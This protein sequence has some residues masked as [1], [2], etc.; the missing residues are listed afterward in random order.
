MAREPESVRQIKARYLNAD[1]EFRSGLLSGPGFSE[2]EME[3]IILIISDYGRYQPYYDELRNLSNEQWEKVTKASKYLA[4]KE[5]KL[6]AIHRDKMLDVYQHQFIILDHKSRNEE[7]TFSQ[8]SQGVMAILQKLFFSY[9]SIQPYLSEFEKA[10]EKKWHE[11]EP[12][13]QSLL[14]QL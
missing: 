1:Y 3:I 11:N 5:N 4:V 7:I 10:A 2:V 6:Q 13:E 8:Y 9:Q 14:S 12:N